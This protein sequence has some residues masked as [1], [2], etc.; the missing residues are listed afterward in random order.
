MW[1]LAL[2]PAQRAVQC[3]GGDERVAHVEQFRRW[4]DRAP[5]GGFYQ[6][7]DIVRATDR[8]FGLGIQECPGLARRL[9]PPVDLL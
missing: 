2:Q 7:A 1:K 8:G 5:L 3:P 4:Q 6:G 9:Q